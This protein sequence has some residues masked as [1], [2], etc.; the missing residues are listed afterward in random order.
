MTNNDISLRVIEILNE[1][2]I[3]YMLV[4]SLSTN[5][6]STIRSTK[7]ADIV[8]EANLGDA[9]RTIAAECKALSLDPQ[10]GFENVTGTKRI[11]LRAEEVDFVVELFS[12]SADPH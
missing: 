11:I 8:V 7:D 3:P 10:F 6:H 4:G 2:Q 5:F 1:H 12:L 9:A